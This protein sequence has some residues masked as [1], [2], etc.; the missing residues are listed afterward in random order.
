MDAKKVWCSVVEGAVWSDRCLFKLS[1]VIEK[2]RDCESCIL[3]ELEQIK[4]YGKEAKAGK[5]RKLKARKMRG[6]KSIVDVPNN[7]NK[8]D[9]MNDVE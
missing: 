2:N 5:K 8:I 3:H 6:A 1:K 4:P 7:I 9:D